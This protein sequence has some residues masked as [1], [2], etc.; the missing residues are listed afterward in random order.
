MV[1]AHAD[2]RIGKPKLSTAGLKRRNAFVYETAARH[3][4]NVTKALPI[5]QE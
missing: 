4:S 1:H 2:D 5:A 3:G